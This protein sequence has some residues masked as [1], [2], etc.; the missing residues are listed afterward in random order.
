MVHQTVDAIAEAGKVCGRCA[1]EGMPPEC[2]ETWA[3]CH[4]FLLSEGQRALMK[5][6]WDIQDSSASAWQLNCDP[7]QEDGVIDIRLDEDNSDVATPGISAAEAS[8]VR[9]EGL[10][11][12]AG[13]IN[14]DQTCRLLSTAIEGFREKRR[15][16][17]FSESLIY[18]DS[19][20]NNEKYTNRIKVL[21]RNALAASSLTPRNEAPSNVLADTVGMTIA[22]IA[23]GIATF[24]VFAATHWAG[25][26]YGVIYI[27]IVIGAYV[28][29]DRLK[30][31]G[32][33]YLQPIA[34]W[35]GMEFPDTITNFEDDRG[36]TVGQSRQF[37]STKEDTAVDKRVLEMRWQC[38]WVPTQRHATNPE[39]VLV[40][41]KRMAV[42]W[43]SIDRQLQNVSGLDDVFRIDLHH[44]CRR[45]VPAEEVH[46]RLAEGGLGCPRVEKVRCARVYHLNLVVRLKSR[47]L[48]ESS[49]KARDTSMTMQMER[50]RLVVNQQGIVRLEQLGG[51]PMEK[52]VQHLVPSSL[53]PSRV[54]VSSLRAPFSQ[55][56]GKREL[57]VTDV[58]M[59]RP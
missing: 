51:Q 47:S 36:R 10:N 55:G 59:A 57:P 33:R 24:S 45:M 44:F 18:P 27:M 56:D 22:A 54:S 30:E 39:K 19:K 38:G 31:W 7:F 9:Q 15:E 58:E 26:Q 4:E 8:R 25:S 41:R 21:K 14:F 32:K 34:E 17:G 49:Q 20:H 29:K 28:I 52:P 12:G 37:C 6:L 13:I 53:I 5:L 1:G 35:F 2:R 11:G 43:Q 16:C 50:A 46:H 42:N 48:P 3:L 23:M 40:Y